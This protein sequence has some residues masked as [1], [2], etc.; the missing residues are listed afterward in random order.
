MTDCI[1]KT[2]SDTYP[3]RESAKNWSYP[4][5]TTHASQSGEQII[6]RGGECKPERGNLQERA[7][8]LAG[9]YD[10]HSIKKC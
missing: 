9:A 1:M 8:S 4:L 7:R 10:R 5:T 2:C 6:E 3:S